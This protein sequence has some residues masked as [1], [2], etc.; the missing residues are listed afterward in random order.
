MPNGFLI[1]LI[2][3]ILTIGI[4]PA[5]PFS[6]ADYMDNIYREDDKTQCREGQ[7]LVYH[8]TANAYIC[9]S[10][11]TSLR[12]TSLGI[13]EIVSK[14][15]KVIEEVEE[16][17]EEKPAMMELEVSQEI[18][19]TR[20]GTLELQSDYLTPETQKILKDEL[21]FQRAI[22]VYHLALPAVAHAGFFYEQDKVGATTGDILYWSEPMTSDAEVLTGN[23]S[24]LY[25][26]SQ[27]DLSDGPIVVNEPA[28][29]ILGHIDNLYQQPITDL[30]APGPHEGNGGLILILPPNYDGEIP[31]NYAVF[32]SDTM[33]FL[34]IA[35]SFIIDGDKD[36]AEKILQELNIYKLSKSD[37]P[38]QAKFF[39]LDGVSIK[40]SQPTTE[41]FWEFLHEVYS[42]EPIVRDEDKNLVGLM[43]AI[44]IVPGEPFEPD[45]H[46]KALLDE[47]AVVADLMARNVAYDSPVKEP[48]IYYLGKNWEIPFM[49]KNAD[50]EDERGITL[51]EPR[52]SYVYQ[53]ITVADAMLLKLEGKGSKYLVNYRDADEN[54]LSGSN[55]YRLNIPANPPAERF[56]SVVVYDADTRSMIVNDVQPLPGIRSLD[57]DT[58]IQND[59]GSYDAYFGPEAPEGYENNWV[60]TNEGDGWFVL[61]RF[62]SPT[63]AFYDKSWQLPMVELIK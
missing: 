62:Y 54:F 41:G 43:H 26:I 34:V 45:G 52:L 56:W 15:I 8:L 32:Q 12:W 24:V 53:A 9:T 63:E 18:I 35:R 33:Q 6:N 22:Q 25:L 28:G 3:L 49:T 44:G 60:K 19:E 27:Q 2:P 42:K 37:N 4:I 29:T 46:S 23:I 47:A 13:A 40:L 30:G 10:Q 55:T 1:I 5:L 58:L 20:I 16:I 51:I 59:D 36:A 17:I 14:P 31:E 61:F 50:F 38:P 21:F 48:Y 7:V 39:D 57:A 11:T